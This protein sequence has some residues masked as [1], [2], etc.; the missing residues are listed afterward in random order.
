MNWLVLS[1]FLSMG[2]LAYQAS[3]SPD[4]PVYQTPDLN[5]ETT[6]GIEALVLDHLFVGGSVQMW[7][8]PS[9]RFFDPSEGLYIFEA[10]L[11]GWGFEFGFR[12]ECDHVILNAFT[13]PSQAFWAN[14]DEFYVSYTGHL[15]VF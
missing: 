4:A 14:K 10:G 9:V 3:F 1:Y 13:I 12:H 6:L 8:S 7:E 5:F 15:K 11:R 2:T